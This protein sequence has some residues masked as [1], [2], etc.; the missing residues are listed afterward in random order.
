M[1]EIAPRLA[2][3]A[4]TLF[5]AL[6]LQPPPW[7]VLS[8]PSYPFLCQ[9]VGPA[10]HHIPKH[11]LLFGLW[12]NIHCFELP[13]P[14]CLFPYGHQVSVFSFRKPSHFSNKDNLPY[15]EKACHQ[16]KELPPPIGTKHLLFFPGWTCQRVI[17]AENDSRVNQSTETKSFT[18]KNFNVLEREAH[19]KAWMLEKSRGSCLSPKF[20]LSPNETASPKS[21]MQIG[22]NTD[23]PTYDQ[24]QAGH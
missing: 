13:L 1:L 6:S 11:L 12:R 8:Q 3:K 22:S 16:G 9:E 15:I 14:R 20:Q 10:Q 18:D 21:N 24:K 4:N 7:F 19:L 2:C 23:M 5:T 17:P